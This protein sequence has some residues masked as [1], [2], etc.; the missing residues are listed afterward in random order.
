MTMLEEACLYSCEQW[1]DSFP[2]EVP[3][4]K[5]SKKHN[6]AMSGLL[7]GK[8]TVFKNKLSKNTVKAL[9]IAAILLALATTAIAV[10]LFKEYSVKK[11]SNHSEYEIV[12][13]NN[14]Y[15]AAFLNLNYIP[16][17]FEIT[18][19]YDEHVRYENNDK[20]FTVTK[21]ELYGQ[22]GFDTEEYPSEDIIINGI[23]GVYFRADEAESG[24][25]FNNGKYIFS[26][27]GN[28]SK[29]ELVK[30]AQNVQ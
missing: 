1:V 22:V 17:G 9:L 14:N 21:Y 13:R 18:E 29:E 11:F 5:F 30:I 15:E 16:Y 23:T 24:I 10:P 12:D 7:Y 20:H 6:Q 19:E 8:K 25:I 4:H 2:L 28:L 3:E 26:V 27:N